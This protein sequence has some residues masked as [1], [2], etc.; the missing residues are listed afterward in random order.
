MF[1]AMPPGIMLATVIKELQ[2]NNKPMP[3]QKAMSK[4]I[5]PAIMAI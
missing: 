2:S 4:I 5:R 1:A 3:K